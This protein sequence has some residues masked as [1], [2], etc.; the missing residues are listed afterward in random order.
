MSRS[1][2]RP[3]THGALTHL[4]PQ[5]LKAVAKALSR[6]RERQLLARLDDHLLRDIG[7]RPEDA[8]Q[9]CAK[10]FWQP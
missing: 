4:V 9:E 3:L 6:R 1:V 8:R 5:A 2:T 7:L 10:P